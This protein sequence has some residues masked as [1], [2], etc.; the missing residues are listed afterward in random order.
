ML[1]SSCSH[2]I[3]E[4]PPYT[5]VALAFLGYL[6]APRMDH[7]GLINLAIVIAKVSGRLK[8]EEW[9][10]GKMVDESGRSGVVSKDVVINGQLILRE[11]HICSSTPFTLLKSD[12]RELAPIKRLLVE[13]ERKVG[14]LITFKVAFV[15]LI[16]LKLVWPHYVV[17]I[18]DV[19]A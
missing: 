14:V 2:I 8:E 1:I 9:V 10:R 17:L 18:D 15:L 16:R 3:H 13:I 4:L 5:S 12:E 6:E 7:V 11:E 19:E